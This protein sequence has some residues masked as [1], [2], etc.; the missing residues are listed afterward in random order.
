[1]KPSRSSAVIVA[2]ALLIFTIFASVSATELSKGTTGAK[3]PIVFTDVDKTTTQG[4]AIY[5]LADAG[6]LLGYGDGTFRPNAPITR[7]ELSKI[8]NAIFG[9]FEKDT[10]GFSDVV[11]EDW[12]YDFVLIAKKAGYIVGYED[13]TF[14]G[15]NMVTREQACAILCRT[16]GLFDL[17]IKTEVRD[18]VSEWAVSYVQAV[19]GNGFISLE[20]GNTLRATE[21][22]TRA[23]FC[24]MFANFY[25]APEVPTPSPTATSSGGAG[26]GGGG[27]GAGGGGGGTIATT[28]PAPTASP[29]ASPAPSTSASPT[30]TASATVSPKPTASP[31]TSPKPTATATA[32]PTASPKPT[33]TVKP[34]ATA[35]PTASPTA[36]PK[37]TPT[38]NYK[39][40][41]AEMVKKLK[42]VR[43]DIKA[44]LNE[45]S[46]VEPYQLITTIYNCIID[47][48]TYE[49][50]AIID[51]QFMLTTPAIKSQVNTAKGLYNTIRNDTTL[52]GQ[53]N[54][55]LASLDTEV[56]L[57]LK[58]E[59]GIM[60]MPDK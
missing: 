28:T 16:A 26:G 49:D 24:T 43:D 36:T 14:R 53:F 31:S 55:G 39:Q 59:F 51:R 13:G 50:K 20:A 34:T 10:T 5:K 17:G 7:A 2:I 25:T 22:I 57:W 48:L 37:P 40:E 4:A 35:K 18:T 29:T 42:F 21:N 1:M 23:E 45:F 6:I 41:N 60:Q 12:Y 9:Y 19:L 52:K 47:V 8:V 15:Q 46:G 27:G 56:L 38:P 44:N 33:A 58:D 32:K 30:P 11:K 54:L 3:T